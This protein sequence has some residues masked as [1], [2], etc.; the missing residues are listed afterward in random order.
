MDAPSDLPGSVPAKQIDSSKRKMTSG[1]VRVLLGEPASVQSGSGS[2]PSFEGMRQR[3][4][5]DEVWIYRHHRPG[6]LLLK[7][8]VSYLGSRN[9][10]LCA[11][12]Q[13]N[14][15]GTPRK[16]TEPA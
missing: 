7:N 9:G 14:D 3:W 6:E 12:W 13:G 5:I 8:M 1:E 4:G 10:I 16:S 2:S 11:G 15:P